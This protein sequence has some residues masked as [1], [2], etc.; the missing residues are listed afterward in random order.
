MSDDCCKSISSNLAKLE[1]KLDRYQKRVADLERQLNSNSN[2]NP[3]SLEA[4]VKA[5]EDAMKAVIDFIKSI[6]PI[7]E[8][9]KKSQLIKLISDLIALIL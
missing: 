9:F 8:F 6:A 1:K 4:R 2:S 7:A 5:L 3:G